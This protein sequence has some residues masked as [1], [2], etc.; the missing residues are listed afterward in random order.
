[1]SLQ[2]SLNALTHWHDVSGWPPN[3]DLSQ[4]GQGR[5]RPSAGHHIRK[6]TQFFVNNP[7]I[8]PGHRQLSA[9]YFVLPGAHW[10][11]FMTGP[12]R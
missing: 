9:L 10:L 6:V 3:D 11:A 4:P 12:L 5:G 1:M 8:A 2:V 7:A